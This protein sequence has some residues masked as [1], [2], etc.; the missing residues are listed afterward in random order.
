[1]LGLGLLTQRSRMLSM[2][3][4]DPILSLLFNNCFPAV[5]KPS[6]AGTES[7]FGYKERMQCD[8]ILD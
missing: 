7:K 1:M 4:P 5:G 8:K 3:A 2:V 6:N